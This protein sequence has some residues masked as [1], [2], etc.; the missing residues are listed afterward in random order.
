MQ[1]GNLLFK[2][3][4]SSVPQIGFIVSRKYGNAIKRNKF[5]R[6]C[7]EILY[8]KIKQGMP[9][10]VIIMPKAINIKYSEIKSAINSFIKETSNV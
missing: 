1:F 9:L 4:K 5:K 3:A 10:Q 8:E 6:R 7:R 2:Y